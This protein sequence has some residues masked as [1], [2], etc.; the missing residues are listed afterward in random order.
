MARSNVASNQMCVHTFQ[1]SDRASQEPGLSPFYGPP[2]SFPARRAFHPALHKCWPAQARPV[3][4]EPVECGGTSCCDQAGKVAALSG[5]TR[6]GAGNPSGS[7][8]AQGQQLLCS[9]D[10]VFQHRYGH[11]MAGGHLGSAA[12]TPPTCLWQISSLSEY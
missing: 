2:G 1:S 6:S 9:T 4:A 11:C 5:N 8:S 12:P 7:L 3:P 10:V